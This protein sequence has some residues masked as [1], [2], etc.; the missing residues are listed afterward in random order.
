[1][2]SIQ[3]HKQP[4]SKNCNLLLVI[5]INFPHLFHDFMHVHPHYIPR[6][7]FDTQIS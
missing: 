4:F 7:F 6:K 3:Y 1:M 5:W 2:L